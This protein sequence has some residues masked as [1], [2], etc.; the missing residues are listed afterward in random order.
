MEIQQYIK[1]KREIQNTFLSLIENNDD[2]N[3]DDLISIFEQ[4]EITKNFDELKEFL[5]MVLTVSNHHH[6]TSIFFDI[7]KCIILYFKEDLQTNLS[8]IEI[9]NFFKRNKIILLFLIEEQIINFDE[10]IFNCINEM[11]YTKRKKIIQFFYPELKQFIDKNLIKTDE[12]E[13]IEYDT[14][15]EIKRKTGENESFIC[16]LIRND[17]VEEFI[18]YVNRSNISLHSTIIKPSIFE[19]NSFLKNKEITIIEYTAFFGSIQIFQYLLFN[20][21]DL[22]PS[23]WSFVIHS[24]NAELFHILEENHLEIPENCFFEAVKCHHNDIANY[25]LDQQLIVFK[26][27]KKFDETINS[28][29]FQFYNYN[30]MPVDFNQPDILYFLGSN[31]YSTLVSFYMKSKE[32]NIEKILIAK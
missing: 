26:D 13:V 19:T 3:F 21:V 14:D 12:K 5:N 22:E 30:F 32:K 17:S 28:I 23:L 24:Q 25:I 6:R 4:Q 29:S 7:I 31:N 9:F 20:N 10:S 2:M 1:K 11:N 15:I 27:Q 16:T 18:S 8:N